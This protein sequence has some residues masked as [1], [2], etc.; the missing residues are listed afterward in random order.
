MIS[1]IIASFFVALTMAHGHK[2]AAQ[3]SWP[4]IQYLMTYKTQ[5]SLFKYK[6]EQLKPFQ[7]GNIANILV[8]ADRNKVMIRAKIQ[9]PL[10]GGVDANALVDL[11]AGSTIAQV[12]FLSIC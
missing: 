4:D 1:A 11:N 5:A 6:N 9:I 7:G 8:D 10:F 12:P 3:G 2:K